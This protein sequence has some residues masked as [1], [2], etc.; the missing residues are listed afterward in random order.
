M[1]AR[2]KKLPS[3]RSS[4]LTSSGKQRV[5]RDWRVHYFGMRVLLKK[6]I[7]LNHAKKLDLS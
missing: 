2:Q 7:S 4:Y 5:H 6:I 1:S 3:Q